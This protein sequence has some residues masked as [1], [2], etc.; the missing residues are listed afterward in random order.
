MASNSV[1][2]PR[3]AT[4][5]HASDTIRDDLGRIRN[6]LRLAVSQHEA[7]RFGGL[8]ADRLG[9]HA[10]VGALDDP[11]GSSLNLG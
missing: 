4:N 5:L 11:G 8:R 2:H 9:R 6:R 3:F 1:M 7:Q 10:P